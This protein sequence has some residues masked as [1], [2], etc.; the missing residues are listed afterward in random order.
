M[1]F[2]L[3]LEAGT[4]LVRLARRA[5]ETKLQTGETIKPTD[6]NEKLRQPSG[7]F[8]T[9]NKLEGEEHSLRGCIGLPYPTM[10]L[11]DAIVD[12]AI[13]AATGDPRFRPVSA[14]EMGSIVVEV[15]VLTPPENIK[16]QRPQQYPER[17]EVGKDG[18]IVS[19]GQRRGLLL[20]QVPVEWDWDA[21]EFLT[22]CCMKAWLPP[23]AW[24]TPGTEVSK[25]SAIIFTE[26]A[27]RGAVRRVELS[28]D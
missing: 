22:Q 1:T 11:A 18:L 27:P 21:E 19:C 17:I 12:A 2:E 28:K 10:P 8:V 25:F 3:S 5:I 9:L 15:S 24:L 23:D 4:Y 14:R 26:E 13:S 16:V 6:A 7:V 20:P